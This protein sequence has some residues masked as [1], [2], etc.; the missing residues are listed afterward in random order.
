MPGRDYWFDEV[1]AKDRYTSQGDCQ[2]LEFTH[3]I[4]VE[5]FLVDK[6]G[7]KLS[8]AEFGEVYSI[9]LNEWLRD[10]LEINIPRFYDVKTSSLEIAPSGK[11]T[12][13]SLFINYRVRGKNVR[14]ELISVDRNVVE[15]PLV[16]L[17]TPPCES[18][19]EL[20][21]WSSILLTLI[22]MRLNKEGYKNHIM[23]FGVNPYEKLESITQTDSFPTCGEHH[24]I[25]LIEPYTMGLDERAFFTNFYHLVRFFTAYLILFS[26]NSP[27]T[28]GGLW[29]RYRKEDPEMPFPRCVRSIR[30]LYNRK[31]LC[32][33]QEGEYM[34]YLEK[35]W[36]DKKYFVEEF[37]RQSNSYRTDTHFLDVDP[38]SKEN[39]TTEIRFFDSQPSIA[40][41][42]G[43]AVLIQMLALKAKKLVIEDKD[44]LLE[45]LKE[46]NETMHALKKT[47]CEGG[48]WFRPSKDPIFG[49]LSDKIKL[50]SSKINKNIL[51]D[52]A[53][54]MIY[55]IRDEIRENNLIYS[56]F[57]DPIRNSIY[58]LNGNGISPAQY[59]LFTYIN[60][61]QRMDRVVERILDASKKGMNMWYDPVVNEPIITNN[62]FNNEKKG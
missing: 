47:A 53:L 42:V 26:A 15:W 2:E 24:H 1:G 20:G 44:N 22:N 4:E 30:V 46:P 51:S 27:F 31:H 6:F 41:R 59:W 9:I 36:V 19:Y 32:N 33:F 21:W 12:Y 34:P 10:A 13:D 52:L 16:E 61:D 7:K 43:L 60:Q 54:G 62:E 23:P 57:L 58:G 40:R 45:V 55:I 3:G 29:G 28:S 49:E 18:L 17:A 37:K 8:H 39:H 5:Y 48:N 25:K 56:H 50:K 38:Y 35:G 14:V 11:S